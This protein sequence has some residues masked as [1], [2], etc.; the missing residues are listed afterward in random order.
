MPEDR[1]GREDGG[2]GGELLGD[3]SVLCARGASAGGYGVKWGGVGTYRDGLVDRGGGPRAQLLD[4]GHDRAGARRGADE[5]QVL[6]A[7]E[8]RVGEVARGDA[9]AGRE[10]LE[11][12]CG[13]QREGRRRRRG[14]TRG[15]RPCTR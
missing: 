14:R 5:V 6:R 11:A 10:V 8:R 13:G 4:V 3:A 9:D 12:G 1:D 15:G 2:E 7:R